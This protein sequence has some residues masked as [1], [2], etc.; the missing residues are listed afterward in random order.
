MAFSDV[1]K[2]SITGRPINLTEPTFIRDECDAQVQIE[3]MEELKDCS[4]EIAKQ[5][6]QDIKCFPM[7]L[8]VRTWLRMN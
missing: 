4:A 1:L 6:E 2:Q 3:K 8:A 5:I 7:V